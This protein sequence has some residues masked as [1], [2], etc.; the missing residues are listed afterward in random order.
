[1]IHLLLEVAPERGLLTR[2][3][4]FDDKFDIRGAFLLNLGGDVAQREAQLPPASLLGLSAEVLAPLQTSLHLV[5]Q[6]RKLGC[7]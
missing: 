3:I 4:R 5:M 2:L 1:V 7:H 6:G